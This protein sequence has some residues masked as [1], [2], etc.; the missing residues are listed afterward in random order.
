MEHTA[1]TAEHPR[2]NDADE[3]TP[4]DLHAMYRTMNNG[5]YGQDMLLTGRDVQKVVSCLQGI[6]A[7]NSILI[8]SADSEVLVLGNWLRAGLD[9]AVHEL[10]DRAT[11][12]LERNNGN[13]EK[14]SQG[15]DA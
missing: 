9:T 1:N 11:R 5:Q 2:G 14:Q 12:I 10:A 13:T 7:I 6:T 15:E 3:I 4:V 8:A